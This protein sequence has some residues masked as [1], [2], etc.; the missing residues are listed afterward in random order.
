MRVFVAGATGAIGF[1][2]V[3]LAR[4]GGCRL[5]TLTRSHENARK[6]A[7]LAD[8]IHVQDACKGIPSLE[9]TDV[10]VS[11]FGA[12]VT[13]DSPERRRYREVDFLGN[14][15]LLD[16]AKAA[17]V[18]R[19][20]YVSAHI[21]PAYRHTAYIQAHESFV[22]VLRRSGTSRSV[23]RPT[24]VFTALSDFVELAGKGV[25]P[26]IGD[27]RTRTNPVH[28]ADVADQIM[29][30]LISGP[31]EISVGGPEIFTRREIAELA[32]RVLDKRPCVISVPPG[33]F[34][35]GARLAGLSNPRLGELLEFAT[36]VSTTDCVAAPLGQHRLE[37][38]FRSVAA[39]SR[40]DGAS[41]PTQTNVD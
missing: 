32:F 7:G 10:V 30:N 33:V 16:A 9:G 17:G 31:D 19:F 38:Y 21:E 11:S 37:D 2:F 36:A 40:R 3:R 41:R 35:A 1:E 14:Q 20:V 12:P 6:L 5:S 4:A 28:P 27:G 8:Q 29:R 18:P 26:V 23:I 25:A 24:G 15:R 13:M 22:E 34:R 39:R